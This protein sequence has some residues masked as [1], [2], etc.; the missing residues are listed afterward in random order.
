M[1]TLHAICRN[2]TEQIKDIELFKNNKVAGEDFQELLDLNSQYLPVS[3]PN[4][5]LLYDMKKKFW[6]IREHKIIAQY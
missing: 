3:L 1:R 2:G 4:L 5:S 6:L